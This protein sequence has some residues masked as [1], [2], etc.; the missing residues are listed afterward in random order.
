MVYCCSRFSACMFGS[1]R[2]L[3]IHEYVRQGVLCSYC[4]F[5]A[6]INEF[7]R[8]WKMGNGLLRV[9]TRNLEVT[10]VHWKKGKQCKC[11]KHV[12]QRLWCFGGWFFTF[13]K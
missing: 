4:V 5:N 7:H 9:E 1:A 13:A 12:Q 2:W 8:I 6:V 11:G 10:I 3:F